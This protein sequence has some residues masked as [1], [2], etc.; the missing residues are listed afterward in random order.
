MPRLLY[1]LVIAFCLAVPGGLYTLS[2]TAWSSGTAT[3]PATIRITAR[4]ISR[5][6]VDV[7]GD[8]RRVGDTEIVRQNL[9]NRRIRS[10]PIG[11]SEFV[12][13]LTTART[14]ACTVTIFLP[15]GRLIA[16]GSIQYQE[17]YELAVLGGTRLYDNARGTLTV[18]RTTRSPQRHILLFRLTG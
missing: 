5:V 9:F 14:R 3:G 6:R 10:K 4:E 2:S 13:T 12:C 15:K 18:I 8:G 11:H 7:G 16:G 17:L 1:M